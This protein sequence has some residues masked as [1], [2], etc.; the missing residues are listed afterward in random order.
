MIKHFHKVFS[1]VVASLSLACAG[2]KGID[3]RPPPPH[4]SFFFLL[5]PLRKGGKPKRKEKFPIQTSKEEDFFTRTHSSSNA[6]KPKSK[7]SLPEAEVG[8]NPSHNIFPLRVW[9][10]W[11]HLLP[12]LLL[13]GMNLHFSPRPFVIEEAKLPLHNLAFFSALEKILPLAPYTAEPKSKSGE[14][15][16]P[17]PKK[18]WGTRTEVK[19]NTT[20][21]KKIPELLK[22]SF[23]FR[24]PSLLFLLVATKKLEICVFFC[25]FGP[26]L[27]FGPPPR[28]QQCEPPPSSHLPDYK[29]KFAFYAIRLL[30]ME[31][32]IWGSGRSRK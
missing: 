30:F 11:P 20:R 6:S 17:C 31:G 16:H 13:L 15:E 26:A 7:Q 28:R 4:S 12:P 32:K 10:S 8:I 21:R 19:T 5:F 24:L 1:A 25:F 9:P 3:R 22:M 29:E 14:V 18:Y 27:T 23:I 2:A